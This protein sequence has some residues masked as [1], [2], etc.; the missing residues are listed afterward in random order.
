MAET[1]KAWMQKEWTP[2][3]GM[4]PCISIRQPFLMA[5]VQGK[6]CIETRKWGTHY[7]GQMLLHSGKM[8]DGQTCK[9][10][11]IY[12][13]RSVKGF[14]KRLDLPPRVVDYPL[15]A[16]VGIAQ[17]V[18]CTT[19]SEEGWYRL[20]EEHQ[21]DGYWDAQRWGWK[22]EQIR[23]FVDPVPFR[24]QLGLMAVP[25]ELVAAQIASAIAVPFTPMA[26]PASPADPYRP[27]DM[28]ARYGSLLAEDECDDWFPRGYQ[29]NEIERPDWM[30]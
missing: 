12:A 7:R 13:L 9:S 11:L 18:K 2:Q 8:W 29:K 19:F 24:G 1:T 21:H 20:Q 23:R 16:V 15:G 27:S 17:L 22:F 3:E 14:V 6:K 25:E 10:D 30:R 26:R 4:I 28:V 5:I